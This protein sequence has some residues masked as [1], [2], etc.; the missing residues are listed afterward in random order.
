MGHSPAVLPVPGDPERDQ[1]S[2]GPRRSRIKPRQ[3]LAGQLIG[4]SQTRGRRSMVTLATY[5]SYREVGKELM[6]KVMQASLSR[7]VLDRAARALGI[8][9]QGVFRFESEEEM[10]VLFDFA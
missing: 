4:R 6:N 1:Q 10:A 2:Q 7:E 5:Q 9:E 3:P 8:V